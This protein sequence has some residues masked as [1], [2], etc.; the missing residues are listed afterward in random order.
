MSCPGYQVGGCGQ[1]DG[2]Y[3]GPA[4]SNRFFFVKGFVSLMHVFL[5][6][7]CLL[8]VYLFIYIYYICIYVSNKW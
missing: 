6:R 8:Y 1:R 4:K 3:E 5:P 7:F 2:R